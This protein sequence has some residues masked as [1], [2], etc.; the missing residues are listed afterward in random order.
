MKCIIFSTIALTVLYS[1]AHE[2]ISVSQQSATFKPHTL[3]WHALMQAAR[4]NKQEALKIMSMAHE[5]NAYADQYVSDDNSIDAF[6]DDLF[7]MYVINNPQRLTEL[8][9]FESIGVRE[10][11]AYLDDVSP[12]FMMNALLN[13]KAHLQR[14]K[15]YDPSTFTEEQKLSYEIFAW[16][17]EHAVSG[18]RF[19]FHEYMVNQMTGVLHDLMAVLTHYH[20]FAVEQD[21]HHY[22]ARLGHMSHQLTQTVELLEYQKDNGIVPPAFTIEKVIHSID[23]L[24]P[25]N[26]T[27]S[28]L[29][30]HLAKQIE[31]IGSSDKEALLATAQKLIQEHVYPALQKVRE[32]F[33]GL[34]EQ[35]RDNHGVW[36]LP[37]GDAYYAYMLEHHTTT[38]LSAEQIHALGLKEV[39]Y[40][41]EQMRAILAREGLNDPNKSVGELVQELSKD[42][43]FYYPNT[44]EGRQQCLA[45]YVAIVERSSK[46]LGKLFDVKPQASVLIEAVPKHME[47]G[48]P[49]GAYSRPSMDGAR[50]GTFFVNLRNMDEVA[51]YG[52]ETLAIH[53]AEPGHHFQIALQQEVDMPMLRKVEGYI[54]YNAYVEGWAL[55]A[56]KLAYEHGF[57]SSSFSELGHFKD[58][59]LRAARLVVDTGIHYKRWSRQE[60]IAYMQE[61]T[62]FHLDTVV[63]EVERYFVL[64]GQA[65]SY[66]IGQLKI[67]ELR[68]RAQK[69][70]GDAF[71]IR[72]FHNVILKTAS[73]PLAVL[74]KVIDQWIAQKSGV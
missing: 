67:L 32:F 73:V 50:P 51:T 29:Y 37:D 39:A 4:N 57:Y 71:D 59:L 64:P 41:H 11:N 18:E 12:A 24:M 14:L 35:P 60:A 47:E 42:L 69:A 7:L 46:E 30:T 20:P 33:V 44:D 6:F 25:A 40:I 68:E 48:W 21:M 26:V 19:L 52:M 9:L 55:Y 8:G 53:E 70:L 63:T 10:H 62:G 2:D 15:S 5:Q 65:C 17:L 28:I 3:Y 38:D 34:S 49:G 1:T 72:E 22:I 74:E 66:K 61:A 36:A 45:D 58:E 23:A 43:K 16:L 56:E 54:G 13:K 31:S 27:D